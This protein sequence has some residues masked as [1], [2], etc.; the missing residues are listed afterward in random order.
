MERSILNRLFDIREEL[1]GQEETEK[2]SLDPYETLYFL[3]NMAIRVASEWEDRRLIPSQ[4]KCPYKQYQQVGPV[5]VGSRLQVQNPTT[6]GRS[7]RS[8]L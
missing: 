6:T 2:P 8:N 7:E 4:D 5:F 1:E 3:I